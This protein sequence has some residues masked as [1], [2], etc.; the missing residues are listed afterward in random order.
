MINVPGWYGTL[1][2]L[3]VGGFTPV[4][5]ASDSLGVPP[6]VVAGQAPSGAPTPPPQDMPWYGFLTQDNSGTAAPSLPS[7]QAVG[8]APVAPPQYSPSAQPPASSP[9]ASRAN[10]PETSLWGRIGQG[11]SDNSNTLLAMGAGLS[12]AP[13]LGTGLSRGFSGAIEGRKLDQAQQAQNQTMKWL[14]QRGVPRDV[15]QGMISNPEI[16]KASLPQLLGAKKLQF[17]D[18]EDPNTGLK[19]TVA[20]DEFDPNHIYRVDPQR[21]L[22]PFGSSGAFTQQPGN[23]TGTTPGA[24]PANVLAMSKQ[25]QMVYAPAGTPGRF[26]GRTAHKQVNGSWTYDDDGSAVNLTAF[27]R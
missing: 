26:G 9:P 8:S 2:P 20:Y 1:D 16:L 5:Q 27:M 14:E 6:P 25:Q 24:I 19:S 7:P 11:L 4:Q 10:I 18:I 22:M 12:G 21:G 13:S 3:S 23:P 15:A 17:K